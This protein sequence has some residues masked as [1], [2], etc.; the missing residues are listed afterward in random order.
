[1]AILKLCR[2]ISTHLK[3]VFSKSH[4][5]PHEDF[6]EPNQEIQIDIGDSKANEIYHDRQFFCVLT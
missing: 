1:M 6:P 5:K 3:I 4:I 2:D